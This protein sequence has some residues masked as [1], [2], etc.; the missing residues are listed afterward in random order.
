VV[1]I[2]GVAAASAK[3][4]RWFE[5]VENIGSPW[6]PKILAVLFV[7]GMTAIFHGRLLIWAVIAYIVYWRLTKEPKQKEN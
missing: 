5:M 3:R 1:G 7:I 2:R 4:R 6:V